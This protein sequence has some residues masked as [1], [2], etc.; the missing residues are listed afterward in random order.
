M[1]IQ[2]LKSLSLVSRTFDDLINILFRRLH[3][4]YQSFGAGAEPRLFNADSIFDILAHPHFPTH[5]KVRILSFATRGEHA[6]HG[7]AVYYSRVL[8]V[9]A[10]P[11][12]LQ[13]LSVRIDP[14]DIPS[15]SSSTWNLDNVQRLHLTCA[16]SFLAAHCPRATTLRIDCDRETDDVPCAH[17][18]GAS[19]SITHLRIEM[20]PCPLSKLPALATA[21]PGVTKLNICEARPMREGSLDLPR[22]LHLG[23]EFVGLFGQLESVEVVRVYGLWVRAKARAR[24]VVVE[25]VGT[26]ERR[27]RWEGW[28]VFGRTGKEIRL[29]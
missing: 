14:W 6:R 8:H 17:S 7:R 4:K 29:C 18:F 2:L 24:A 16:S 15:I 26:G 27:E 19:I 20:A 23:A 11:W 12:N 21:Y 22:D 5:A 13:K 1:L 3:I 9:M 28:R 25:E 10:N